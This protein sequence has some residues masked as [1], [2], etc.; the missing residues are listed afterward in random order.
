MQRRLGRAGH[1]TALAGEHLPEEELGVDAAEADRAL[2]PVQP[3][4]T[5]ELREHVALG[6]A[7]DEQLR[8]ELH[9]GLRLRA[10]GADARQLPFALA[11]ARRPQR[12]HAVAHLGSGQELAVAQVRGG[13]QD[14]ELEAEAQPLGQ[15]DRGQRRGERAQRRE[16]LDPAE[17]ALAARALEVAPHEQHRLAARGHHEVRVLRR[18]AEIDEVGRLH[19]QRGV[20]AVAHQTGLEHRE[21]AR[22]LLGGRRG[23]QHGADDSDEEQR[24]GLPSAA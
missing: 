6:R 1:G 7:G 19:E 24:R 8:R 5:G 21:T 18:A 2:V 9:R 14:V 11:R 20:E 12:R 22:D 17:R 15:A 13:R 3:H 4:V 10:G 16:R 23:R